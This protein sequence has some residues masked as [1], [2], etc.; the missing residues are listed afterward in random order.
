MKNNA[1]RFTLAAL[2]AF[3]VV[4]GGLWATDYFP[5]HKFYAAQETKDSIAEKIGTIDAY[6]TQEFQDAEAYQRVYVLSHPDIMTT[7]TK[8]AIYRA[9]LFWATIAF[10]AGGAVLFFT[11]RNRK[12][13]TPATAQS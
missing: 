11:R 6:G 1:T 3:Y 8:L 2:A 13:R 5:L 7:E 10:G 4:I 12:G 9:L